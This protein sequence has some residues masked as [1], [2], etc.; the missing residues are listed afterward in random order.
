MYSVE[1]TRVGA[2]L[3]EITD[4]L[5]APLNRLGRTLL[6]FLAYALGAAALSAS[7]IITQS[8]TGSIV[9]K[10]TAAGSSEVTVTDTRTSG[11]QPWT[12]D[13]PQA[14]QSWHQVELQAAQ[15]RHTEGVHS[16]NQLRTFTT[17]GNHL[18]RLS[19]FIDPAHLSRVRMV[20][21][22]TPTDEIIRLG[23]HPERGQID[24]LSSPDIS[25]IALGSDVA[26]QLGVTDVGAGIEV[27]LND[28]PVSVVAIFHATGDVYDGWSYLSPGCLPVVRDQLQQSI[29]LTTEPGYAEPVAQV[30]PLILEPGNPGTINVSVVAP[31]RYQFR[32]GL[33]YVCYR[34]R[35]SRAISSDSEHND[36]LGRE[37][38]L[39]RDCSPPCYG[40]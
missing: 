5:S 32:S 39:P 31:K 36:V 14:A 6:V 1:R 16:A 29:V 20:S 3:Q 21:V 18:Q 23:L 37:S 9:E 8:T 40:R 4:A 17:E 26:K 12:K 13:D 7:A 10:L 27:W 33:A 24:L 15:L 19:P 25:V 38:P 22:M 30:V 2:V 35:S 11:S 34:Y 28:R